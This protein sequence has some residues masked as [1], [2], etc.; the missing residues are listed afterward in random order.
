MLIWT[1]NSSAGSSVEPFLLTLSLFTTT[2]STVLT[3]RLLLWRCGLVLGRPWGL[4]LHFLVGLGCVRCLSRARR[5][6]VW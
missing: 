4:G 2:T 1:S 6:S 5:R 3:S